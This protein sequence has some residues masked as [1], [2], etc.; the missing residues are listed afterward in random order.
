MP[1]LIGAVLVL[2]ALVYLSRTRRIGQRCI[3]RVD[4]SRREGT[5]QR[6]TCDTC[7][8]D[9]FTSTGRAPADCKRAY[10]DRGA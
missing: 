8:A 7:G 9:A 5:L 1:L 3:W 4:P 10:R 2:A 6:Y